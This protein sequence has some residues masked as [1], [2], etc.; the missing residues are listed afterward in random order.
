MA[1]SQT[2]GKGELCFKKEI[3]QKEADSEMSLA[4]VEYKIYSKFVAEIK[5]LRYDVTTTSSSD[6]KNT[7]ETVVPKTCSE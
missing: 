2:G 6:N 3:E 1:S 5:R 4:R 7:V